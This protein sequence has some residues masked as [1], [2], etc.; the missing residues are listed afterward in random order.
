MRRGAPFGG[1]ARESGWSG[2]DRNG[3]GGRYRRRD[4]RIIGA[5]LAHHCYEPVAPARI[6][7]DVFLL[8]QVISQRLAQHGDDDRKVVF[9]D[10]RVRPKL[11][12]EVALVEITPVVLDQELEGAR[13]AA[14]QLDR[15]LVPVELLSVGIEPEWSK[16]I[17]A[18]NGVEPFRHMS[19][20][21][22]ERK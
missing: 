10:H 3:G 8:L 16:A 9:L 22:K 14:R 7:Q 18:G 15:L 1:G 4:G 21:R 19:L 20:G 6:R 12:H 5:D 2:P 11:S 13:E 17:A